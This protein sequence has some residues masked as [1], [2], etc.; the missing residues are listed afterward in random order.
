MNDF[1]K[2]QIKNVPPLY[3]KEDINKILK[4][5]VDIG[6][7]DLHLSTYMEI[8][9]DLHGR[10]FPITERRMVPQEIEDFMKKIYGENAIAQLNSGKPVDCSYSIPEIESEK[11]IRFRINAVKILVEGLPGI[12]VTI[13]TITADPPPLEAMNLEPE[14][15][16]NFRPDQGII[17]VTGPTGSGKS[18]LLAACM[19]RIL[20]DPEAYKKI[21]TYESPI[22]FTYDNVEKHG[23]M[24]FQTEIPTMLPNFEIGVESAMR[25]KP[26]IIL[27]G[28]SRDPETIRSS[29]LASQT[30]HLVYTTAHTNGVA[31][32]M[33]RLINVFDSSEREPMQYDIV[34]STKMIISQRLLPSLDG[35]RIPIREFL[36]FDDE[37]KDRL[38]DV[39]SNLLV[40]ELRKIVK[41]KKQ[42]LSDDVI[43]KFERGLI[44]EKVMREA[45]KS[46]K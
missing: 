32:T 26:E 44:S 41:S 23:N 24:I 40:G 10:K 36:V 38:L 33:R 8:K 22:E 34:D 6:V 30:G 15:W 9:V 31:E 37:I 39:N 7:S 14:I 42:S 25:R 17:L 11:R 46:Y 3:M 21:V 19:R 18:T 20:E 1:S 4:H 29:V 35:K 13:R 5:A 28:E 2:Y 12:Q 27:I 16:E 43:R 45:V